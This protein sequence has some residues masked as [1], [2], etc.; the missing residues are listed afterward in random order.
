[1]PGQGG[2]QLEPSYAVVDGVAI[3]AASPEGIHRAIDAH[4]GSPI[5]DAAEYGASLRAIGDLREQY[6][7]V[8]VDRIA[9]AIADALPPEDRVAFERDVAPNLEPIDAL[10]MGGGSTES[11]SSTRMVLLI[12]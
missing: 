10:V 5:V 4:A 3:L 6:L 11:G 8:D 1:V 2:F 7:Y 12:Q 9:R